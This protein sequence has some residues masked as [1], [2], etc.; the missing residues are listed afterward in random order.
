MSHFC[1]LSDP[2]SYVAHDYQL[3]QDSAA[4]KY[5]LDHFASHFEH[6]LAHAMKQY[7]RSAGKQIEA[8]RGQFS[9]V[10]EALRSA[11]NSLGDDL[12]VMQL[13][14]LR[15]KAL[16]EN[17]LKDPFGYLK[18]RENASA[19]EL[20]GQ[21]IGKLQALEGRD[22]WLQLVLGVFA[23]NIFDMGSA[24]T[25]HLVDE[26]LEREDFLTAVTNSK[27]RPWFVD[28]FDR[29]AEDLPA[30][31][32]TKW[33]KA[34]IF[35]DN[36]GN[37][38]ILG[39]MPL[40]RELALRG[41][42]IVLAANELP[43]LNDVTV[44]ETIEIVERLAGQD[45]DLAALIQAEMFEVV[46]TGN[47]LSLIDLSD[48]SDELNAATTDAELLV[49]VG[50]GRSV[51]SN[52]DASFTVDALRLALLKDEQVV[53]GIGAALFDCICKYVPKDEPVS[54]Q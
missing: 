11:P 3:A 9:K 21:V 35:V 45:R 53:A 34:V 39:V 41:T 47:D 38:L 12:D 13:C 14:R 42:R 27:P 29:L 25:M 28:D 46:S 22:K 1:L 5:W 48:V 26:T 10:I 43:C 23:G 44:D 37:D 54:S 32:P 2:E 51:E 18:D 17:G 15:E 40:A 16:R 8:A 7:G 19:I 6:T 31:P 52:F 49:L 36:A 33:S 50:M 24:P 4:L 20:Y 30:S